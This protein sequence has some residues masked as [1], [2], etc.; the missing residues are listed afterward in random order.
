M[1]TT[2]RRQFVTSGAV[3][4]AWGVHVRTIRRWAEAG[5]IPGA[6]RM[7]DEGWFRIPVDAQ[8]PSGLLAR[9][10]PTDNPTRPRVA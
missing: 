1:T 8:P 7:G 2:Q 6:W 9:P 10:D 5:L 3:A 4:S